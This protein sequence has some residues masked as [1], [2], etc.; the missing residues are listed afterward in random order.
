MTAVKI[1]EW[2]DRTPEWY[3]ARV[4]RI[5]GSDVGVLMGWAEHAEADRWSKSRA[6]L[7]AEKVGELRRTLERPAPEKPWKGGRARGVY[8]EPAIRDWLADREGIEYD[9]TYKGTWVD[10]EHDWMMVNPDGVTTDGR[11]V[12][13]KTCDVRDAEHGWGRAGTSKIPLTYGAQVTWSLGILGLKNALVPVLSGAPKFEF[14]LYKVKFDPIV[15]SYL[16]GNARRFIEDAR[17][18]AE[19]RAA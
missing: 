17:R 12:E 13:C 11:L 18:R 14:A 4:G 8:C 10:S 2:P 3:A 6:E 19:L 16:R 15:F 7:L 5:G 1:G 9:P